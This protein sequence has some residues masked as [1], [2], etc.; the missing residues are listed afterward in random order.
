MT[1]TRSFPAR[2]AAV[3]AAAAACA[4]LAGAAHAQTLLN[5]I[6]VFSSLTVPGNLALT[7][8]VEYPTAVSNTHLDTTYASGTTYIGYFD[9]NK[10]YTYT[11]STTETQRFFQPAGKA[12]N[13]VCSSKWSGN[14]LNWATMQTIDPFRWALTGGYRS[15]DDTTKT[16]IEKAYAS[17]QGGSSNFPDRQ[18]T[19]STLISGATPMNWSTLNLRIQGLGNKLWFS[20]GLGLNNT[21]GKNAYTVNPVAYTQG[22]NSNSVYEV[23]VRARVCDNSTGAGGVE[24][25]CVLYPNGQYKPEGLI[26]QYAQKIRFSAFGYLNDGALARDGGVLRARMKFVGPTKPVPGGDAQTNALAEWNATTGIMVQNPDPDDVT[27]TNSNYGISITDSGVMNY[28]N[29]FGKATSNY[30]TYD[31][32][33]ELYYAALRYFR[34]LGNVPEWTNATS[35]ANK[36]TYA[37]GF[38]VITNWGDPILYSCQKNFILGIGDVNTHADRDLPGATGNSEPTQP[39]SVTADY[40]STGLDAVAWTNKV[41]A[42]Q[43]LGDLG[44]VQN[45]NGCCNNNGALM[46]GLAYYANTTDIRS[47]LNGKQ[48]IRTYWLDVLEYQKYVASNQFYLAAKYGGF[49]V[50]SDYNVDTITTAKFK[51]SY[52][53]TGLDS[54]KVGTQLRP[55]TYFTA[56]KAD[57]MVSGL[58]TAFASIAS[59]VSAYTSSLNMAGKLVTTQTVTYGTLYDSAKWTGD[60]EAKTPRSVGDPII[61]NDPVWKFA[62][63]L[64]AQMGTDGAG[65]DSRR[66]IVTYNPTA[67]AGTPFRYNNLTTDQKTALDPTWTNASD[68]ANYLN[69]LRG[70]QSQEVSSTVANSTKLYRDRVSSK[71]VGDIINSGVTV[72]GPV[73]ADYLSEAANPGFAAFATTYGSRPNILIAGANTGLVH[74]INGTITTPVGTAPDERGKELFAFIPNAAFKGPNNTPSVDGL[75]AVG[76][77]DYDHHYLVDAKPAVGHVNFKNTDGGA[78]IATNDWR[79][80]VVGGLGKGGRSLYALDLTTA[81]NVASETSA[82]SK[83]LWE[84]TDSDMGYTYGTPIITKTAQYGWVVVAGTG[85]NTSTGKGAFVILNARTGTLLQK[86]WLPTTGGTNAIDNGTPASPTGLSYLTAFYPDTK[87]GTA[88]SV[89]AGDLNGNLWRLD[90]TATSGSYP[91]PVKIAKLTS[92]NS[93]VWLPVTSPPSVGTDAAGRRWVTVGTGRLLATDDLKTTTRNRLFALRDGYKARYGQASELPAGVSWPIMDNET[94][95]DLQDNSVTEAP[96]AANKAGYFID[97]FV[98]TG[99]GVEGYRFA[100]PGDNYGDYIAAS[101]TLPI[102]SDP[103]NSTGISATFK[104]NLTTGSVDRFVNNFVV[105]STQFVQLANGDIALALGGKPASGAQGT[106]TV[107][108]SGNSAADIACQR[109]GNCKRNDGDTTS[110]IGSGTSGDTRLINWREIPLRN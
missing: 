12:T 19:G 24:S 89:Y 75:A 72:L 9:P 2:L 97:T 91:A 27:A 92:S 23:S 44:T 1:P 66:Y 103:C 81:N 5:N 101:A 11:T 53:H 70:D 10:C 87:E 6:P 109:A 56:S 78:S 50:P 106:A 99:S 61:Y 59:D 18:I 88:E 63:Q 40:T 37:D 49:I 42:L 60:I 35:N 14:F 48:T 26:Q 65:W 93:T 20:N 31:P 43:G 33:G 22:D 45:Y 21:T 15:I 82:A 79:S 94:R 98:Q 47:D 28:L 46:A 100:T 36:T 16:V 68:G 77:P 73:P 4:A 80:I 84:Y 41:G 57:T 58:A 62:A 51:D 55:D 104:I 96:L 25:N 74:I 30:K 86:I 17:G 13:H 34:N 105:L 107:D 52:W 54:D 38:P 8:S 102:S 39:A 32:V 110:V 85:M 83:V 71:M 64:Q 76:N 108:G 7:L 29:K 95:H 3:A 69:W 67:K 90:L